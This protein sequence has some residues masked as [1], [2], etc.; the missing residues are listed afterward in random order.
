MIRATRRYRDTA[1]HAGRRLRQFAVFGLMGAVGTLA[2]YLLLWLLVATQLAAPVAAS[3]AGAIVGA[4]VNYQLNYRLTF[5]SRRAHR[6]ALPRFMLVAAGGVLLN[7]AVMWCATGLL[8]LHWLPAQLLATGIV[9][10][11]GYLANCAWTFGTA[12]P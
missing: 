9:L 11:G 4:L 8:A 10:V 6:E 1:R 7:A 12:T 2:H 3:T 5:A